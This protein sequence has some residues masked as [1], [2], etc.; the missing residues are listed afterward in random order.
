MGILDRISVRKTDKA[1]LRIEYRPERN[2]DHI[3]MLLRSD[4]HHDN[5]HTDLEM[6]RRHLEEAKRRDALILD[7]G[8]LHC[9]M[10]GRW[11]RRADRSAMRPEYQFGNYLDR[12]VDEAV[13]FYGPYAPNWCMMGLGNHETAILKH[14]ETN[15]TERVVERLKLEGAVNLQS[16]GYAGW[17]RILIYAPNTRRS[18]SLWIYRHHGYGGGGPVTRGTIQTSRMA[19]YLPDAQIVWTGHTHDQWIMPIERYRVTH[20]D[21]PYLDRQVHIRTPG[22]KDEFSPQD[23]W[24]TERGGPPKP[25]GALWIRARLLINGTIDYEITEAR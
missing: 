3:W 2:T 13:K 21:S 16:C 1:V 11:D 25:R 22:Y 24:H 19:V 10:Q 5:A 15:L 14:H 6:E 12:L 20:A 23:G 17:V 7:N 4:A 9:A 8:D 18:Q